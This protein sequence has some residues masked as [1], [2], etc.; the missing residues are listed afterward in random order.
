MAQ[1]SVREEQKPI[2]VPTKALIATA[3]VGTLLLS[4]LPQ[5]VLT[6]LGVISATGWNLWWWII[7]GSVLFVLT[8]VW[9]TVR[10]LREYFLV[11]TMI[12][13]FTILLS[14]LEQ[15]SIW[16]SWFG[17]ERSWTASFFGERLGV[18][19]LAFGLAGTLALLGQRRK[20]YFLAIGNV[21][22][23]AA[24]IRLPWRKNP[25]PWT[26]AALLVALP[27]TLLIA[28]G[29]M[30]M[31]PLP[32]VTISAVIPLL[33]IVF[34]FA[35]MNAF[36]EELAYRAAPLSQLWGIVGK[37]QAVWMI[38]LW[39]G[40]GHYYGGISF[41][42][43]GAAFFTV[44]AVLFGKAMLETRGLVVPI[45]MHLWGDVLLYIVLVLAN[46]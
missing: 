3:W 13:V 4:R 7:L 22:A 45:F 29:I 11:L 41:G 17:P 40:L 8:Y 42:P 44:V 9:S 6:E 43:L 15:T 16:V 19:L 32:G 21:K 2:A 28:A 37:R 36:G 5:I 12:Y 10:P 38:A 39:F 24:G 18:V 20:D 34:L 1:I 35:L 46:N 27:L 31:N 23:P 25:L 14:I 30:V 26:I 33:P